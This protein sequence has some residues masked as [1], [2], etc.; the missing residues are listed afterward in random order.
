MN[1]NIITVVMI[2]IVINPPSSCLM[3]FMVKKTEENSLNFLSSNLQTSN[4]SAHLI[5][6]SQSLNM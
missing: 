1:V 5:S 4:S 6:Q 2:V 3:I